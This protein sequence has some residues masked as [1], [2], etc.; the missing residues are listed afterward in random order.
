[1]GPFPATDKRMELDIAGVFR[2]ED[3]KIAEIWV[4]WD[5][6]A[7]LAQLGHVPSPEVP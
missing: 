4:T 2:I 3:D 5:N 7:G 1:M 6:M